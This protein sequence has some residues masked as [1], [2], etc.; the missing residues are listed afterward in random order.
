[1]PATGIERPHMKIALEEINRIFD[2]YGAHNARYA[3]LAYRQGITDTVQI[4]K[5]IG[6][7]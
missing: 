7:I 4:L 3:A 6:I 2:L 1:M 5:E